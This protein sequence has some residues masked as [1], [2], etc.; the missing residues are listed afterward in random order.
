VATYILENARLLKKA[1]FST[2]RIDLENLEKRRE[3]LNELASVARASDS[4]HLVFHSI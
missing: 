3:M 1:T 4:C 2:K